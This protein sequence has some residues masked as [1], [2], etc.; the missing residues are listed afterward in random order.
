MTELTYESL[1]AACTTGGPSVLTIVTELAPAAGSHAAVAPARYVDGR[2][3]TYAFE[4]RYVD[5]KASNA[6]LIDGKGSQLNRVEDAI[7]TAVRDDDGPLTATPRVVVQYPGRSVACYELPHRAFDGHIRAGSIDGEPVTKNPVYRAAR[8]ATALDIRALADLSGVS[9]VLGA[10]DS[11]R[12]SNQVRFRSALVG[13]IVGVLAD[14]SAEGM[15][16]AKRGGARVDGIAPSVRLSATDM[17][18]LVVAQ[19]DELSANNVAAIRKEIER[20]KK[21]TVSASPLGLGSVPPSLSTPGLVACQRIIR[22]QVLS[23]AAL[24][25]LRFGSGP[26]GDAAGRALLA[27]LALAG[28]ARANRELVLRANCDLVEVAP[29]ATALDARYGRTEAVDGFEPEQMDVILEQAISAARS[30]TGMRW[31][32]QEFVV[33]GS[34]LVIQGASDEEQ[35]EQA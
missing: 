32:G 3:A 34:P 18:A 10:W 27:A 14:Q 16:I 21:G 30:M 24:R 28:L 8:D 1:I 15:K 33:T 19:E 20:N 5:G 6:V 13:E 23:F 11:T 4:T 29:P 17:E 7:G 35:G 26:A 9:P 12:R 2:N 22:S 31:A 25:Q